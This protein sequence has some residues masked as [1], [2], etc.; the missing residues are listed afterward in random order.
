MSLFFFH[1]QRLYLVIILNL[2][3]ICQA[4]SASESPPQQKLSST[5]LS[6]ISTQI[7]EI[8]GLLVDEKE[9]EALTKL[10]FLAKDDSISL[11]D[12]M[13]LSRKFPHH[14]K[15]ASAYFS[16]ETIL[17][18]SEPT[19]LSFKS[20]F[21]IAAYIESDFRKKIDQGIHYLDETHIGRELQFDPETGSTFIHLGTYGVSPIGT[22]IQKTVT[23]T[24]LYRQEHS[25]VMARGLTTY[26]ISK[27]MEALRALRGSLN[28]IDAKSLMKHI[29]DGTVYS[30]VITEIAQKGSLYHLLEDK[31][32]KLSFQDK[33]GIAR[34]LTLGLSKMHQRGYV[35]RDLGVKNHLIDVVREGNHT[36][37][38][39]CISDMGRTIPIEEAKNLP[40]QGNKY[41]YSPEGFFPEKMSGDDYCKSDTY[42]MGCVL[43]QLYFEKVPRW[44]KRRFYKDTSLPMEK[45]HEKHI[46]YQKKAMKAVQKQVSDDLSLNDPSNEQYLKALY[47]ST[48]LKM[49]DIDP[50]TRMTSQEAFEQFEELFKNAGK[51][52]IPSH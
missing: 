16:T 34:D 13:E 23:K 33:V 45:R 46:K 20:L 50:N 35:H 15:L 27:E 10:S 11:Q 32:T 37:Y 6:Q 47:L 21:P 3:C 8:Q 25:K 4:S 30:T 28:V 9:D 1:P 19:G 18:F 36:R 12:V 31:T 24:I 49:I 14:K 44:G 39:A 51:F 26:N 43:W 48:V 2:L 40:V 17:S 22:G 29:V 5:Q 38:V 7:S 52:L 42:A 41:Y